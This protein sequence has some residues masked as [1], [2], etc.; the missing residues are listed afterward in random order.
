MLPQVTKNVFISKRRK[1]VMKSS[2]FFV[3]ANEVIR[4]A[5]TSMESAL[6][7]AEITENRLIDLDERLNQLNELIEI[8]ILLSWRYGKKR[9][10]FK[11]TRKK[12]LGDDVVPCPVDTMYW[13]EKIW[14]KEDPVYTRVYI[15]F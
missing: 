12:K 7:W 15:I 8:V 13:A 10:G 9:V 1:I 2:K 5:E 14:V 3:T 6:S 11:F 4:I